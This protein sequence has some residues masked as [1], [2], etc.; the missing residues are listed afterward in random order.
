M[1]LQLT[2]EQARIM[3]V[4]AFCQ[5]RLDPGQVKIALESG[6]VEPPGMACRECGRRGDEERL[7]GLRRTGALAAAEMIAERIGRAGLS[8][9]YAG[10]AREWSRRRT[11]DRQRAEDRL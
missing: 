9:H 4:C 10:V 3:A 7:S 5:A 8:E 2:D 6:A 11:E 1:T